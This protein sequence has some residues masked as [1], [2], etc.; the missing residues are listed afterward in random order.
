MVNEFVDYIARDDYP[1]A[2]QWALELM[3]KTDKLADH[4]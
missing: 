1:T 3:G 4:P 2:E